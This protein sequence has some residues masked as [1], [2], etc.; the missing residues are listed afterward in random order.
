MKILDTYGILKDLK[1]EFGEFI[2]PRDG[3]KYKTVKVNGIEW[4]RENLRYDESKDSIGKDILDV[5][6]VDPFSKGGQEGSE[7]CGRYYSFSGAEISC[8]DGWEIPKRN[9]WIDLF[10]SI[11]KKN[12]NEWKEKEKHMIYHYLFGKNS[13]LDLKP[14]GRYEN[15][16]EFGTWG[17]IS[18]ADEM[19]LVSIN[20]YGYYLTSTP[21]S[22][23]DGGS[24]FAINTEQKTYLE[25]VGYGK[26]TVRPI[27]KNI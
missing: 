10:K 19:S 26:Y 3:Q 22:M 15:R 16:K 5:L 7:S 23:N 11:T 24:I 1:P 20:I 12:P 2:D 14:C 17:S 6:G 4:F 9:V 8:P 25:D 27:R 13:I 18:Q 21:G